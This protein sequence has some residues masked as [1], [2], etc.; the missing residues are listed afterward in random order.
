MSTNRSGHTNESR[1]VGPASFCE[2]VC[3]WVCRFTIRHQNNTTAWCQSS[4][5]KQHVLLYRRKCTVEVNCMVSSL[6]K[7]N[8]VGH[9]CIRIS[10]GVHECVCVCVCVCIL[11]EY[12]WHSCA[13]CL[14]PAGP[15]QCRAAG[16]AAGV[17]SAPPADEA[18]YHSLTGARWGWSSVLLLPPGADTHTHKHTRRS[19]V[20]HCI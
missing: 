17:S 11:P 16:T 15:H 5:C 18:G 7:G 10:W 13:S 3:V 2:Q 19:T 1:I 12:E 6:E 9:E 8:H 14:Q 4:T 20:T